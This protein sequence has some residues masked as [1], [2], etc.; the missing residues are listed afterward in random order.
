MFWENVQVKE[1]K[2]ICSLKVSVFG[3]IL[4]YLFFLLIPFFSLDKPFCCFGCLTVSVAD[5]F[6]KELR[7]KNDQKK[8]LGKM[9]SK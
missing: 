8:Y 5:C 7:V 3:F 9:L 4:I 2:K 1:S 6:T